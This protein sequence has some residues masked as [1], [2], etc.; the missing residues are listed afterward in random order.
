[1]AFER[2][3][4]NRPEYRALLHGLNSFCRKTSLQFYL[5]YSAARKRIYFDSV[6]KIGSF[7][8][9]TKKNQSLCSQ[10]NKNRENTSCEDELYWRLREAVTRSAWIQVSEAM[11]TIPAFFCDI[12]RHRVLIP[13][14]RFGTTYRSYIRKSRSSRITSSW[15]LKI[16]LIGY[17]ET[18]VWNY[19]ST[20]RHIS[21]D[22][23]SC[24]Q[25]C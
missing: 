24:E 2:S 7:I 20:L 23:G 17:P 13:Y 22:G 4:S 12:T 25:T 21:E 10:S 11:Q 5:K 18:S 1:M 6:T 19:P 3:K 9:P 16:G 14:R 8:M 15:P